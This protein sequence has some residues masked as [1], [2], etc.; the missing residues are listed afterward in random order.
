M[1]KQRAKRRC[2]REI[3]RMADVVTGAAGRAAMGMFGPRPSITIVTFWQ[4][5]LEIVIR[6]VSLVSF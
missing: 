1:L 4:G 2:V 5:I 6:C 3:E